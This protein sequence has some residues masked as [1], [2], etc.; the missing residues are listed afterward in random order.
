[1]V[2]GNVAQS[3]GSGVFITY[4]QMTTA[5]ITNNTAISGSYASGGTNSGVTLV[6][7]N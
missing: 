5:K 3:P 7:N 2:D 4:Q 6:N 1:M